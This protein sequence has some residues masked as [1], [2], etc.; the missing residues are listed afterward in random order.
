MKSLN[1]QTTSAAGHRGFAEVV[2]GGGQLP[3][4]QLRFVT[5]GQMEA[6][7][8]K[9]GAPQARKV[10]GEKRFGKRFQKNPSRARYLA[11]RRAERFAARFGGQASP[12]PAAAEER[13]RLLIVGGM[14]HL[15]EKAIQP[16]LEAMPP[17]IADCLDRGEHHKSA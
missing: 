8:S 14:G 17:G 15:G 11:K 12:D 13:A 2:P 16:A 7:P 10:D 1:N 4:E 6:P 3:A 5:D 9:N